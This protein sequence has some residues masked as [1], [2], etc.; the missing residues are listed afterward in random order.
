[1]TGIEQGLGNWEAR[2]EMA[3][4]AK[5]FSSD[6]AVRCEVDCMKAVGM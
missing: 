1:M 5:I 3:L 6:N 4:E 2:L